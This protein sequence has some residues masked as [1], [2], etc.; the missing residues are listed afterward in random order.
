MR[1]GRGSFA[2]TFRSSMV[3][4]AVLLAGSICGAQDSRTVTEPVFPPVCS[5]LTSQ[6]AIV[7]IGPASETT[8]DTA[9]IQ[10]ALTA[11]PSGQAVEL[12]AS[13]SN[14]AFLSAPLNIPSGVSLIVDG[15]VSLFAS[16][17]L[18]D[19]QIGT[20]SANQDQCGTQG[21]NG[22]GCRNFISFNNGS[23]NVGSGIYGFGVID[24]RGYAN[25]L[26]G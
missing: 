1:V 25:I 19:Y 3:G 10:A 11:C 12:S 15:G 4:F 8:L 16:R 18:L 6:M 21:P 20:V 22:N 7:G 26:N 23:T 5:V 14:Y 24:G 2:G 13:G 17:N 9:R